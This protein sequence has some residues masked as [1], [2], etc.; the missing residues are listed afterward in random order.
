MGTLSQPFHGLGTHSW[1]ADVE[2][3]QGMA[4]AGG[5][6]QGMG[7]AP[8]TAETCGRGHQ[9]LYHLGRKGI[10]QGA[11]MPDRYQDRSKKGWLRG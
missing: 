1:A 10:P 8:A 5:L 7:G 9:G 2:C 6:V 3:E 4:S 11:R